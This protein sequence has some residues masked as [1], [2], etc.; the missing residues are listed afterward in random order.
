MYRVNRRAED[1]NRTN[2]EPLN[3]ANNVQYFGTTNPQP[4]TTFGFAGGRLLRWRTVGQKDVIEGADFEATWSPIKNFQTVVNGAWLWTAHTTS[5][6]YAGTVAQ[7]GSA[8][9]NAFNL[10]T[11]AG[12]NNKIASDIYFG[13]RLEN[14]PEYR[15][16]TFSKYTITDGFAHGL[17]LAFGTRYSSKMVISRDVTWNPLNG[18]FQAGNY[19]VM[20]ANISYP[21]EL[22]GYKITTT[23]SVQNLS[24][25]LYFE[26]GQVASPGR[27]FWLKNVLSF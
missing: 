22:Q 9:Y 17:S 16:N 5:I 15:F 7:P 4:G 6:P 8:I 21:W 20:D 3:G 10:S 23:A 18:G 27:Q 12:M 11:V 2:N 26:G 13:A 19:F 1:P 24:D 25:K 14:V